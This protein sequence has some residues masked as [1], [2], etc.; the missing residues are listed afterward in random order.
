[1]AKV[2]NIIQQIRNAQATA[3]AKNGGITA[4]SYAKVE[5]DTKSILQKQ[6]AQQQS[7]KKETSGQAETPALPE[8]KDTRTT[9]QKHDD[10]KKAYDDYVGSDEHKQ[11]LAEAN[12][13]ALE[14]SMRR[15]FSTPGT[16]ASDVLIGAGQKVP[17]DTKEQELKTMVDHYKQQM[18][19]EESQRIRD[20]DM[21]EIESWSDEDREQL[22]QYISSENKTNNL[23]VNSNPLLWFGAN[24]ELGDSAKYLY[25]KYGEE[26][27]KQL[28]SSYS[29]YLNEEEAR[30]IQED[31]K[32]AV[33]KSTMSAIGHN[34]LGVGTRLFGGLQATADRFGEALDRD[35]R[36]PTL[37]PYT[38]G[39]L[40]SLHGNTVTAQTA[41]NIA[42]EDGGILRQGAAYLYQGGMTMV[43]SFARAAAGGGAGGAAALAACNAFSQTVSDASR[44]G[45]TPEQA[46]TLGAAVA[47]VEYLSEKI[48]MDRVFKLAKAGDTKVLAQAF[49]QAGIEIS[50]EELS[51]LGSMAAEAAILQEKSSYK[52]QIG[53]L[54]AGGTSYED[55]KAQADKAVW[56]EV[57]QTALVSGFAGSL[58]GGGAAL[59]GNL[60]TNNAPE[61]TEEVQQEPP[62][63]TPPE[64]PAVEPVQQ[65][66]PTVEQLLDGVQ[67]MTPAPEP[68][69]EE[70]QH[71]DNAAAIANGVQPA[72]QPAVD[73]A[74]AAEYDNSN[75]SPALGASVGN[76]G[77]TYTSD[78][79]AVPFQYAVVPAESLITSND[80]FGNAN[81]AYPA[82]LQPRDRTR[83]ASQIQISK[84]AQNLNPALL[85]ESATAENGAPIIRGDG[86]VVGGNARV[87]AIGM[88]YG[89]GNGG[90][91]QQFITEKAAELGIDP[92]TLPANPVLVRIT[93]GVDN[94]T[95]L[96]T[97]LNETGVKTNSPSET[98]KIDASK[99][100]DIIQYLSVGEDGDLNTAENRE[101]I[102]QFTTHVV[103]SGEQDTVMQGNSQVSQAGV[104]RM[105]YALFHYAYNDTALLERLA[106]S[107]DNNAKNITN[108]MVGT[109]GKVAQL[110]TEIGRGEVQDFGLQSAITNAV[111]LYLD[112]K[113][114]KQT[115]DDAAGQLTMGDNGPEAQ[116]DGLTVNLAKFMEAN[117]RSGKQIRD[118]ID[119]LV[120]VNMNMA[121]ETATEV[122]MF[123]TGDQQ[124]QEG[125]YDEAVTAYDQQRDGKGRIP[126]KS[127]FSQHRQFQP[128]ELA[129]ELDGSSTEGSSGETQ[130]HGG[131]VGTVPADAPG[132]Q[133]NLTEPNPGIKGTGA[134]EGNF[135]GKPA[136][137]ATLSEDNS[138]ADRR[139][140]VR[141]MELPERDIN[142]GN[143]SAV[144]GNVYGSRITPD[145]FASL[146]EEPTARG[147]FSYA[148]IT[149]DQATQR[150]TE[151]IASAGTWEN[152]YDSWKQSVSSG[153]AGAEMSA[154]GALLLNH[155][156]RQGDKQLWLETLHYMQKLGTNTAQGLQ[157]FRII[158]TLQPADKIEFVRLSVEKMAAEV[159]E[160]HGIDLEL[161]QTLIEE[162]ENADTDEARDAIL[163]DI[164]Q[165]VASQIPSTFLDKWTALRYM[166]MLGNLK[167][168]VRNIAG[169]IGSAAVYRVK[170]TIAT[171]ME[172]IAHAVSGGKTERTKS[173]FVRKS[174]LDACKE[175]FNQFKETVSSGGK[176]GERM[177]ASSQFEQGVQD[178]RRIFKNPGLEAYR[179]G[180]NWMMNNGIFGD[181]AF[182]RAAYSRALAGYLQ[183]NG[184]TGSDLSEVDG[185]LL[186]RAR[187]YAIKEA[188]EATFHDNSTLAQIVSKVQ[189]DTGIVGQGL[190]PF[191]K[192]P[193]NVL[194]RAEE[195][196]PLGLIN[197]T[198]KSI[199]KARG[200]EDISGADVVNSWAKTI[201]GVGL[202]ALG[203]AMMDQ[204]LLT[205]GPD[206]DEEKAEFDELVGKQNYAIQLPGGIN[207]TI[208]WLT[209][210]AMPMFMGAQFWKLFSDDRDLTFADM[211]QVFTS[212]A[213]PMIQ[214]SMLQ[215]LNDSLD[216]I[217]YSDNNLGQ[218]FINS[219]VSYLTQGLTNT[220]LGQIERS[221]EENRQTTYV[222]KNSNVP[223]WLQRQLGKASQKIPGWDYQQMDY[224]NAFGQ[225]EKN[226]GGLLYNMLS[227]GYVSEEQNNRITQELYRLREAT[228]ENVFPQAVEK[229]V[230]YTDILGTKHLNH[231]LTQKELDT[232]QRVEGQ[233][234]MR[235]LAE[236]TANEDYNSLTDAQRA[237]VIANV[238]QYAQEQGKKDA[239]TGYYSEAAAWLQNMGD[240]AANVLIQRAALST[241][242][243]SVTKIVDNIENEWAV[244]P[245]AQQ[246]LDGLYDAYAGMSQEARKQILDDAISDTAK[247]LEIRSRG[248]DTAQYMDVVGD[249]KA[250]EVEPNFSDIRD[251]QIR[252]AIAENGSLS[253][254]EKD[255]VMRAYMP[256]Y[257]PTAK[258]PQTTE[259]KYD[260]IRKLGVSPEGYTAAY[261]DYLDASGTGKR[262]R[263]IALYMNKYGWD[264]ST[265][266]K[267]YDLYAG[268]WKPWKE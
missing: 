80:Q 190:M 213:D 35:E 30:K 55:A 164:Q 76:S 175:D 121:A 208:D 182:G 184:V 47:G 250:L 58:S 188:Q 107:T 6:I 95:G 12:K 108:A 189:K 267:V 134:A 123:D 34:I 85:A 221:T 161:D 163:E 5:A 91:Y 96:A 127:D 63:Q 210:A 153:N 122:S 27:T 113:A 131:S 109:A 220:L 39:D 194:T 196:S 24:K 70:L 132:G 38:S 40:M 23:F 183:A 37:A 227:P 139:D 133:R 64:A 83:T 15:I 257:D 138:Q 46:Y 185:T 57:K 174:L 62:V 98:A 41:Q 197:S 236:I 92:A 117:N 14:E 73:T 192:T 264:R 77:V 204:G 238:Y 42:G 48:P 216:G 203:A 165:D 176:Y 187:A 214:M 244:S 186:D 200:N 69:T 97:A 260:E 254:R 105:Q 140:D 223:E 231:A 32:E 49:K 205:G 169:N 201:T 89:S 31:T 160:K 125:L 104:R 235:L 228:G 67:D 33:N 8:V 150:A 215:G 199:Q 234:A 247:Y 11:R 54:V 151:T 78:N 253:A 93:N 136:Y 112:A 45:A 268:Y 258:S 50:T 20:A 86:V 145:E 144:T 202:F 171:G 128:G 212:I 116:H 61:V 16:S 68:L 224:R 248:L 59:V 152:A 10:A 114:G 229:T 137:N 241:I 259:L 198:V 265:A 29:R 141:P 82:E 126:E 225:T 56:E 168:N 130:L 142:G 65:T 79:Q 72:Q 146:M 162:F 90:A 245:A 28:A 43:D 111:N 119:I 129:A 9:Q 7:A 180:T 237:A 246:E 158:R 178:K 217:K 166:N 173:L 135:S 170:D 81:S 156:A 266:Q 52:Q 157:A 26:K 94:Y 53:D 100:G 256:D 22:H 115:V 1:M 252:E 66:G 17:V 255:I 226:E 118:F 209:P 44:Q 233:T 147:D 2:D 219:A 99:M 101:F 88:A 103:P 74:P 18:D 218:F 159:K 3:I 4:N 71:F 243:S 75:V 51:L 239:L 179:K 155:A 191:T 143:V 19:E 207:Y 181:E 263:T 251:I 195:F 232:I 206:E 124:T 36:Y 211:E 84:M 230:T 261:R 102:Q 149:N 13:T 21:K 87:N 193:A 60:T 222:D 25:G 148:K 262:R 167:T 110:Q 240:D 172:S 242:N 154:R 106:E 249:I 177:S 120:D